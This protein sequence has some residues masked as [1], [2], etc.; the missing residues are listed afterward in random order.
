MKVLVGA[1]VYSEHEK[2]IKCDFK[3]GSVGRSIDLE[4]RGAD[5]L[6]KYM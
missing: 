5:S 4:Q 3:P 1:V 6:H 2:V